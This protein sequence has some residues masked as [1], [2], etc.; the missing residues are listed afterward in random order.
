[1][2]KFALCVFA[3]IL[4]ACGD[5][6]D[7]QTLPCG[8][9]THEENRL[10]EPNV[11]CGPNEKSVVGLCVPNCKEGEHLTDVLTCVPDAKS[12]TCGEGTKLLDN[13]CVPLTAAEQD[14]KCLAEGGPR[15]P[16]YEDKDGDGFGGRSA[17]LHCSGL[18]AALGYTDKGGDCFD[19]DPSLRKCPFASHC[20]WSDGGSA[21]VYEKDPVAV[22][23]PL[24]PEQMDIQTVALIGKTRFQ[25]PEDAKPNN[26]GDIGPFCCTGHTLEVPS[27]SYGNVAYAHFFFWETQAY[28][29]GDTSYVRDATIN[30]AGMVD[31]KNYVTALDQDALHFTAEELASCVSH[32]VR[33]GAFV[34]TVQPR[35]VDVWRSPVCLNGDLGFDMQTLTLTL[36][37]KYE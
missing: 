17:G 12:F 24:M 3:L 36:D 1:M 20:V 37:L 6:P 14:A 27:K 32:T 19:T 18:C 4:T 30:V 11:V 16:C 29:I 15:M 5:T 9:G 21:C 2:L 28:I 22:D 7:V 10:C 33:A 8:A 31:P 34:F 25:L 26:N 13:T 23:C 35:H